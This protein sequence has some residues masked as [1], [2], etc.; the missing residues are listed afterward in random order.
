MEP[1][2]NRRAAQT[3]M[4]AMPIR[5]K[6]AFTRPINS[7]SEH[8]NYHCLPYSL[9]LRLLFEVVLCQQ[10]AVT[11]HDLLVEM[12]G[13]LLIWRYERFV[14]EAGGFLFERDLRIFYELRICQ[15]VDDRCREY[16]GSGHRPFVRNRSRRR[17]ACRPVVVG[18]VRYI[19]WKGNPTRRYDPGYFSGIVGRSAL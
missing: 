19:G 16:L 10:R 6:I 13:R 8:R 15:K 18:N 9:K 7:P 2:I 5:A 11:L 3:W 4:T 14:L 17:Y 12:D 1:A